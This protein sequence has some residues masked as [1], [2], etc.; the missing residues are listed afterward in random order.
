MFYSN[1]CS[2]SHLYI[3]S[4]RRTVSTTSVII[5]YRNSD[6]D[7]YSIGLSATKYKKT[8]CYTLNLILVS[9]KNLLS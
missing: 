4:E 9:D 1:K 7:F 3:D 5:P 8:V 2:I 6:K